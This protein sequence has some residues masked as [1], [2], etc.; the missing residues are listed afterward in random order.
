MTTGA[1]EVAVL[2][3]FEHLSTD[4]NE[5]KVDRANSILLLKSLF[6]VENSP[7]YDAIVAQVG[8]TCFPFMLDEMAEYLPEKLEQQEE[9]PLCLTYT[10]YGERKSIFPVMVP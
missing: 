8:P 5:C 3:V 7:I 10:Y 9:N 4:V 2:D 1:F 6:E